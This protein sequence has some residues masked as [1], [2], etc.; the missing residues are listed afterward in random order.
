VSAQQF[1][2]IAKTSQFD[3]LGIQNIIINFR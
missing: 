3:K 1:Q 2:P